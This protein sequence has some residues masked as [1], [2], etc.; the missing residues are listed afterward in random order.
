MLMLT[1]DEIHE[2]LKEADMNGDG[3]V[4][5]K[6]RWL[7]IITDRPIGNNCSTIGIFS[8]LENKQYVY[9]A[10]VFVAFHRIKKRSHSCFTN[11]I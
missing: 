1:Q 10:N 5:F 3:A 11:T 9:Y 6:G 8:K 4:D 2:M 7:Q